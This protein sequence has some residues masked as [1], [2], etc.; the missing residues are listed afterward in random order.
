MPSTG[1]HDIS[2]ESIIDTDILIVGFGF[3]VF[4]L[5]RELDR[6][7]IDYTIVSE[8]NSV[9]QRLGEAGRLDFDLVSSYY[10]SFY[11]FDQVES[12]RSDGYP[13]AREFYDLQQRYFDSYRD[14][15]VDDRVDLV[16]HDGNVSIV[17][18]RG[19][20][21]YR[22]SRLVLSTAFRRSILERLTK[23]DFGIS[24]KTIA[25]TTIGDSANLMIS[26]LVPGDNEIICLHNGFV[27]VDKMMSLDGVTFTLDQL[28]CHNFGFYFRR[29]YRN[30]VGGGFCSFNIIRHWLARLLQVTFLTPLFCR[31]NFQ[32]RFGL[33]RHHDLEQF[34][35]TPMPNGVVA[36]KYWPIDKYAEEFGDQLDSAVSKGYLLNDI[37]YFANEGYVRFWPKQETEIDRTSRTLTHDGET[38]T[39]DHLIEADSEVPNLPEIRHVQ[40]GNE[41][42]YEYVYRK[43]FMGVVS[44]ALENVYF[45][46]LTRPTTGGLANITEMQ[47]LFVHKML[48]NGS[49]RHEVRANLDE[50]IAD[51]NRSHYLESAPGKTDHL[52]WYGTYTEEIARLLGINKRLRDC[53][54]LKELNQHLFLPNNAF[55]YRQSGDYEVEGCRELVDKVYSEHR[56]YRVIH[57]MLAT[58][59]LYRL[60]FLEFTVLLF[61]EDAISWPLLTGLIVA[62]FLFAKLFIIPTQNYFGAIKVTYLS[63]FALALPFLGSKAFLPLLVLDFLVTYVMRQRGFRHTFNDLKNKRRYR[64]FFR[65]YLDA[66]RAVQSHDGTV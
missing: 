42:P 27:P 2:S 5:L 18:T 9:W 1:G 40:D 39:Y 37:A 58:F 10:T 64:G 25:F 35:S 23:F 6:D 65:R 8:R 55:K 30:L 32:V 33:E 48:T 26:K 20:R 24:G 34:P 50:R 15:I 44:P 43:N 31:H 56:K 47:G 22:A 7:C 14:R 61:V 49:F 46:G 16:R 62:Q 29:T 3:S 59:C 53:R 51:Y 21:I 19:G 63:A 60:L 17:H 66:Y 54:S 41:A 38:L 36:L 45:L 4:P 11:S 28:E 13:T 57:N 52:V 12:P